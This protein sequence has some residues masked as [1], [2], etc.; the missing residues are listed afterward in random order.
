MGEFGYNSE[1]KAPPIESVNEFPFIKTTQ[2]GD[3]LLEYLRTLVS[4]TSFFTAKDGPCG[5]RLGSSPALALSIY[6][7]AVAQ[8]P[9]NPGRLFAHVELGLPASIDFG[10]VVFKVEMP[11]APSSY[12]FD[13]GCRMTARWPSTAGDHLAFKRP[14]YY[15]NPPRLGI[16]WQVGHTI[17]IVGEVNFAI[18][19]NAC[20]G[21]G[22]L[23]TPLVAGQLR[24][25]F[26]A[27]ADFLI[28][29]NP[30]DFV[31]QVGVS[32]GV[33]CKVDLLITSFTVKI[34]IGAELDLMRPTRRG[35]VKVDL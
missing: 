29:W 14:A 5:S 25:W 15:P 2:A 18:T 28:N 19:T 35:R 27:W 1:V 32:I 10:A 23:E 21:G 8:I 31:G 30:F 4:T 16:Y 7:V 12:I 33:S 17:S 6:G 22:R 9:T 20:I 3:N 24:A 34:E 11:L 26:A 13:P